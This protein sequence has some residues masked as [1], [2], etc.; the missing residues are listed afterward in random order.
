MSVQTRLLDMLAIKHGGET[1]DRNTADS[2]VADILDAL[3][4]DAAWA[5][6]EAAKDEGAAIELFGPVNG[7]YAAQ[8]KGDHWLPGRSAGGDSPA[9]ALRALVAKLRG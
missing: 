1:I 2:I 6:A 8:L 9:A 4:L 5:E 3:P 7:R